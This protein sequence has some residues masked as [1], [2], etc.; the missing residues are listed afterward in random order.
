MP[1]SS[2]GLGSGLDVTSIV[3]RLMEVERQPLLRLNQQ[4]ARVQGA[5]SAYG[6]LKGG[7]ASVQSSLAKLKDAVTFQAT[8]AKSSDSAVLG[9]SSGSDA[10]TSSYNVTVNRLAQQHKLG[11]AEFAAT[12]TFGGSTGDALT[13]TVGTESFTLDLSSAKTLSQIQA[14]INVDSNETGITAGLIT[15]DSGNQTL[16]MTSGETGYDNR[17]QLTFAGALDSNTFNFSLLNRDSDNQLLATENELDAALTVDGV[18]VT[19]SSNSISDVV[20]GLSFTLK[21]AGQADVE[22]SR[23]TSIAVNAVKGFT[24]AYNQLKDQIAASGGLGVSGGV[25]RNIESLMR[26]VLNNGLSGLGEYAYISQLGVTTDSETGKL[27]LDSAQLISALEENPDSV[28]GF[29]SNEDNGFSS[30]LDAL[31]DG[32]LQSGGTFDSAINSAKSRVS[33]IERNRDSMTQRMDAIEQR[34]LKQFGALDTLM[35]SMTTTSEYL[36]TQLDAISNI[37]LRNNN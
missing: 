33:S 31:L 24:T 13:L 10:V 3:S 14:A 8:S 25:L 7:L 37:S 34:Y 4:E 17:V 19:R 5:I 29:F 23:D 15:G 2:P 18:A 26:G 1:I 16:V 20:D 28:V 35:A 9:V 21:E 36:T 22:I 30:R 11:S 32:F 6:A 27:Q 12:A